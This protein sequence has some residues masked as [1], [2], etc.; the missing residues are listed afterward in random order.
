MGRTHMRVQRLRT[1]YQFRPPHRARIGSRGL[2]AASVF[3]V[4]LVLGGAAAV[5]ADGQAPGSDRVGFCH[6]TGS[7]SQPYVYLVVDRGSEE[8]QA[9]QG[10]EQD[11]PEVSGPEAC[12]AATSSPSGAAQCNHDNHTQ[13]D[14]PS[15][16]DADVKA[17][18]TGALEN[19]TLRFLAS[20][21]SLGP[22]E[23]DNV[24]L[25]LDLPDVG[26]GWTLTGPDASDCS[27]N[28]TQA[29]CRFGDLAA[30]S[31]RSVE[32]SAERCPTDCGDDLEASARTRAHNDRNAA[33]DAAEAIVVVPDC[34]EDEPATSTPPP[35]PQPNGTTPPSSG[36]ASQP[37]GT[38]PPSGNAT[39]PPANATQPSNGS[40]MP[41][42]PGDMSVRPT[43]TQDDEQA[44]VTFRV[45][46][47]RNAS[48]ANVTLT[49]T[50]PDLRRAWMVS[51]ADSAA[52]SLEGRELTCWFGDVEGRGERTIEARAYTDRVP[53]GDHRT[54]S[55][56]VTS[57]G[58]PN[59]A[60]D[61]AT[62]SIAARAC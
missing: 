34:P 45:V 41:V 26:D 55:V 57:E 59:A 27:L 56:R 42:A 51:G 7:E 60:N 14:P 21:A 31:S 35:S 47:T 40:A 32:A 23:A 3:T 52:C 36:N 13:A 2:F 6:A 22:G 9:H 10:H 29:T 33:N 30:G 8:H 53:C 48:A 12:P 16:C 38:T 18:L 54:G 5:V 44:I 19:G 20:A 4:A 37:N 39:A 28:G 17:E 62:I 46:E 49:A 43:V 25:V 11:I 24:R 50:L 1:N 58:D 15:R 61:R